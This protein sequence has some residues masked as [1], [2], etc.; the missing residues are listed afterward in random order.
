MKKSW[1]IS[2]MFGYI[3]PADK[4]ND[5]DI[6]VY[7]SVGET[8]VAVPTYAFKFVIAVSESGGDGALVMGAF[9]VRRLQ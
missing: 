9:V 6:V 5:S 4:P 2:Q 1:K 8:E 3:I 7:S